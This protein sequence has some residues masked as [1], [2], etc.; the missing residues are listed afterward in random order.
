MKVYLKKYKK[1]YIFGLVGLL[2]VAGLGLSWYYCT[3]TQF[4]RYCTEESCPYAQKRLTKSEKKAF[5]AISKYL[6]KTG[7]ANLDKGVLEYVSAEELSDVSLKMKAALGDMARQKLL[8]NMAPRDN[9]PGNYDCM[10]QAYVNEL[11]NE[12]TLFLQFMQGKGLDILQ[13]PTLRQM[14]LMTSPK[15]MKCMN[16][17]IQQRYLAEVKVLTSQPLV[18]KTQQQVQAPKPEKKAVKPEKA[19]SEKTKTDKKKK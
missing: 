12:E 1:V 14:Y 10:R 8:D 3:D 17:A 7:Q 2:A 19:K 11:S 15:I 4:N 6:E 16:E 9:F 18:K 5:I 13:N